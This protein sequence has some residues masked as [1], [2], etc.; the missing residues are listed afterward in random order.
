MNTLIIAVL[1]MQAVP[2]IEGWKEIIT[3]HYELKNP[4]TFEQ[5]NVTISSFVGFRKV[6][7]NPNLNGEFVLVV[8]KYSPITFGPQTAGIDFTLSEMQVATNYSQK[9]KQEKLAERIT[10]SD[11]ILF[12]RWH[13]IEDPKTKEK[14][15]QGSTENWLMGPDGK[16]VFESSAASAIKVELLSEPAVSKGQNILTGFKFSLGKN[17]HILKFDQSQF[18]GTK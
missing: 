14:V 6:Y 16:W 12:V 4:V 1:L 18:G 5:K 7:E 2:K 9:E 10:F 3:T 13:E 15:L 8:S 11:T 17:Y